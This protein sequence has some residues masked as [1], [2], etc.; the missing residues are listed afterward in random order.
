MN[1][2]ALKKKRILVVGANG[3]LGSMICKDLLRNHGSEIQE[4]IAA[5]H[6]VGEASTRGWGRLSYEIGA[7]DGRG[8][9]GAAWSEERDATFEYTQEMEEYHLNKVRIVDVELLDSNQVKAICE[10]VDCIIYAATDFDGNTPRSLSGFNP[11]LLFRAVASPTKGRVEI[12]GI[13]NVLGA[14]TD[15][16]MERVRKNRMMNDDALRQ[17][18]VKHPPTQFVLVSTAPDAFGTW[19]TPFGEFNGLKRQAEGIL[20]NDFPSLSHSILQFAKFEDNFVPEG[21]DLC[22]DS[23]DTRTNIVKDYENNSTDDVDDIDAVGESKNSR[24]INRRDAARAAVQA[25]TKE[26]WTGKTLQIYTQ[27]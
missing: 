3:R 5:V 11:A 1:G 9:I 10:D 17:D 22:I 14:L 4:L 16:N 13:Q 15:V 26:E 12:E 23:E 20:R 8:S 7:E 27:V 24:R 6:F 19:E 21:L 2:T 25:L 18:T